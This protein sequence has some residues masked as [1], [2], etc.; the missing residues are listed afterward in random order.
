MSSNLFVQDADL[1]IKQKLSEQIYKL[2][3]RSSLLYLM[4]F[5]VFSLIKVSNA[6]VYLCVWMD[7]QK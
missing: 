5:I 1:K 6:C 2:S 4:D 3:L 7:S